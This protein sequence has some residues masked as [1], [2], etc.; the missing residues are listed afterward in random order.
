ML[1]DDVKVYSVDTTVSK[2]NI[3]VAET[4]DIQVFDADENNRVFI[5]LY[6]DAVQEIV[7][8]K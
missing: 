4:G 2:N 5:K 8:I 7:I 1:S 6:K 3:T